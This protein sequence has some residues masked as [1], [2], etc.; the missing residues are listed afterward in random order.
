M[1]LR[2]TRLAEASYDNSTGL[3]TLTA[4]KADFNKD[5]RGHRWSR[6]IDRG[7]FDDRG[8]RRNLEAERAGAAS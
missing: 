1:E 4:V 7:I 5:G 2:E 3:A 6:A 8:T